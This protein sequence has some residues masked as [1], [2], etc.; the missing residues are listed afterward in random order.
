MNGICFSASNPRNNCNVNSKLSAAFRFVSSSQMHC[1]TKPSANKLLQPILHRQLFFFVCVASARSDA[2]PFRWIKK[3]RGESE[4]R[5]KT[6]KLLMA[7]N[8][9]STTEHGT[10]N[11]M[12]G[13]NLSFLLIIA[14]CSLTFCAAISFYGDRVCER[15][16]NSRAQQGFPVS[17][18]WCS[19]TYAQRAFSACDVCPSKQYTNTITLS[20]AIEL[21]MCDTIRWRMCTRQPNQLDNLKQL[22]DKI[23]VDGAQRAATTK[24]E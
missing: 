9:Y 20:Y 11:I 3:N 19:D 17:C 18:A 2:I 5:K 16:S 13:G 4:R 21:L 1:H 7:C 6:V 8:L 10:V 24:T 23:T 22:V 14:Q 15:T 12:I